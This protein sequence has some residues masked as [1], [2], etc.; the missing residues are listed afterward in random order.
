MFKKNRLH[1]QIPLTSHIDE[2]PEK[3]RKCLK[4]SWAGVFYRD[5]FHHIDEAQCIVSNNPFLVGKLP[6]RGH[7]RVA[8]L[9]IGLTAVDNVRR[10]QRCLERK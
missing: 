9:M 1:L 5:V 8:C 4:N 10:I 2:L 7:F 6:V 3:L